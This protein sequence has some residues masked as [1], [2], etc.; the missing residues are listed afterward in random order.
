M[1]SSWV[2]VFVYIFTLFVP[3]LL[4]GRDFS[5]VEGLEAQ[6]KG[7]D[8]AMKLLGQD[9]HQEP[10]PQGQGQDQGL[11]AQGQV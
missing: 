3:R 4:P 2:C 6:G 1:I 8:Q 5:Y 11:N 7:Q 9:Q 10:D